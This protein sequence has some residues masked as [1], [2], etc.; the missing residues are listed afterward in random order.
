MS[1]L[2]GFTAQPIWEL[3]KHDGR[4]VAGEREYKGRQF[5]ELRLWA[6]QHGD[7]ATGKGVTLPIERVGE[8]GRALTAYAEQKAHRPPENGSES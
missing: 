4:L 5:F 6:G 7:K 1:E 3:Q 8:L 2:P